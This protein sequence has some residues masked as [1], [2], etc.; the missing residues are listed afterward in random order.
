V[1]VYDLSCDPAPT[2]A[3][4][5]NPLTA[6]EHSRFNG[7]GL[8]SNTPTYLA[9]S[10]EGLGGTYVPPLNITLDLAGAL[11]IR[12]MKVTDSWGHASVELQIPPEASGRDIWF[13]VCQYELKT[14]VVE[15]S[16]E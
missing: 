14:N 16:I 13:Q 7:V 1:Y 5:P 2:L 9:Y 15:T 8:N 11:R 10:L 12:S 6:G 4:V 3:V